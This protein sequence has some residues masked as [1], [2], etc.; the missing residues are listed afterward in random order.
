MW[1]LTTQEAPAEQNEICCDYRREIL[2][3][4]RTPCAKPYASYPG[5]PQAQLASAPLAA[6]PPVGPACPVTLCNSSGD[7]LV[8]AAGWQG[9]GRHCRGELGAVLM[10]TVLDSAPQ[11]LLALR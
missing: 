3:M 9:V 7:M 8:P 4:M 11:E 2:G 10:E 6:S 5:S 1:C